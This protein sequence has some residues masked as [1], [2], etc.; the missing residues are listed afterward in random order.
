MDWYLILVMAGGAA[1]A[2]AA[3]WQKALVPGYRA[4]R[5]FMQA[6]RAAADLINAQLRPN[7]G[8][9]LLDR[10]TAVEATQQEMKAASDETRA[11]VACIKARLERGDER[12]DQIEAR[13]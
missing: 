11:D 6:A 2:I 3:V 10:F 4:A 7:H 8:S 1:T 5:E 9:S 13:L 12:F